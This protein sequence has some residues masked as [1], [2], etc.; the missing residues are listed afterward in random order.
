M[1]KRKREREREYERE[2]EKG[3]ERAHADCW[4]CQR[5]E[6]G[7]TLFFRKRDSFFLEVSQGCKPVSC[8]LR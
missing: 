1:Q 8:N 5:R 2:R 3:T 7:K 4:C 6:S